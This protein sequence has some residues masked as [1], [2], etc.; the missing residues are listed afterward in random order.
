M[1]KKILKVSLEMKDGEIREFTGGCVMCCAITD[2]DDCTEVH[3]GVVDN[4]NM[5]GIRSMIR[6][7]QETLGDE[8]MAANVMVAMEKLMGITHETES[9]IKQDMSEEA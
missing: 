6:W 3:G 1:D 5:D 4:L 8:W 2:D 9:I 7:Q